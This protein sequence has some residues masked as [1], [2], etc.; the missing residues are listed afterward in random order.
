MPVKAKSKDLEREVV[1]L[2]KPKKKSLNF[3]KNYK[4][5]SARTRRMSVREIGLVKRLKSLIHY[6]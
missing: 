4:S 1:L 5:G 3:Y 6:F 2:I